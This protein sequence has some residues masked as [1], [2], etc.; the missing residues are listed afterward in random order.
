MNLNSFL[1]FI[2]F[3]S[4][5]AFGQ[6][7]ETTEI[8]I[9]EDFTPKIV[10][11]KKINDRAEY[12]DSLSSD[13]LQK[14][15]FFEFTLQSNYKT[16]LLAP[17]TIKAPLLT[18]LYS[19]SICFGFGNYWKTKA[20]IIYNSTRSINKS[21]G[22]HFHHYSDKYLPAKNSKNSMNAFYKRIYSSNIYKINLSYNR[23]TAFYEQNRSSLI[24]ENFR[25]RFALTKLS[26]NIYSNKNINNRV[27]HNTNI[28]ISD[29][30]EFSENHFHASSKIR[31]LF[32][33]L[34]ITIRTRFD[35][36]LNYNS[37]SSSFKSSN[38]NYFDFSPNY[39]LN[40]YD[41]D[42]SLG[43]N[44]VFKSLGSNFYLMPNV[45]FSKELVKDIIIIETG[46]L[47]S[48]IKNSLQR[49]SAINPY[50]HSYGMNQSIDDADKFN[51][52][53]NFTKENKFYFSLR[54]ILSENEILKTS[55]GYSSIYNFMH[56]IRFDNPSYSRY[57]SNYIDLSQYNLDVEYFNKINSLLSLE[58]TCEIYKWNKEV[59]NNPSFKCDLQTPIT[60]RK[61][62]N[63]I[64]SILYYSKK[65]FVASSINQ[66]ATPYV[67]QID[68]EVGPYLYVNLL[69][70][71]NYSKYLS[72]FLN[73]Y[74]I[75]NNTQDLW[76]GYD[77]Q[78]LNILFGI[79][80]SF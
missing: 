64:P 18:K 51:Q 72:A 9:L 60:L 19:N 13:R 54:N 75:T 66:I 41:I 14:Y 63:I 74:N 38:V 36:Y 39:A 24:K 58:F 62:I 44:F 31:N 68:Q 7:I 42:M 67:F 59:F 28:F 8:N 33:N 50:I 30:N 61:K 79:R 10:D 73:F 70:E 3:F 40:K 46:F 53:L 69:L 71:Y 16:K 11:G 29:F 23:R 49:I 55:F 15:E 5:S 35:S 32:K 48:H 78:G 45:K 21:Y 12:H 17:A 43:F 37:N 26:L 34:P 57:V 22:I 47:Q 77:E 4:Y 52:T 80:T 6:N 56:F 2:L 1:F 76:L 25:N 65:R 27:N 20:D